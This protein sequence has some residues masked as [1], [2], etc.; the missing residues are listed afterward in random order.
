[1][2]HRND[3]PLN[4]VIGSRAIQEANDRRARIITFYK[5]G[6]PY[7][8]GLRV[9]VIPG[10]DFKTLEQLCIYLTEKTNLNHGVRFIFSLN[11]TPV[12]SLNE[13]EH[14]QAYVISGSKQFQRHS[15]GNFDK[16]NNESIFS[17]HLHHPFD[18]KSDLFKSNDVKLLR[19]LS[20][21]HKYNNTVNGLPIS[22]S[23]SYREGRIITII[24]N[25]DHSLKSRVLLNLSNPK[26]FEEVLKDLGQAVRIKNAKRMF[27]VS[28]QE[29]RLNIFNILKYIKY[30]FIFKNYS[31]IFN[32]FNILFLHFIIYLLKLIYSK[33]Q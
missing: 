13:L 2:N 9:S 11:G 7:S 25:K 17:K 5:N 20:S 12:L 24:N 30:N 32:I 1:M 22:K 27:T 8:S 31:N 18:Q 19:P 4:N 10:R 3:L 14:G 16:R 26:P 21:R 15:Y 29:V 23:I 28:G 33:N 6:E